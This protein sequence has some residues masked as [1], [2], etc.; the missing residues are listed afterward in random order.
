MSGPVENED[1]HG[2]QP[3][4]ATGAPLEV[5]EVAVVMVHGRGA[6]ANGMLGLA[7]EV[8]HSEIAYLAP[9]AFR[10]T[11]Y[12]QS[13]LAPIEANEPWLTSALGTVERALARLSE[14]GIER[15]RTVL[16]GFS[17]GACLATEFAARNPT[18]YGGIV[19]LSG[20]LIG[21]E[22]SEFEYGGSLECTPVFL[23]CSDVDPHIPVERVHETAEVFDGLGAAVEKRIYEGMGHTVN[24]EEIE[25]VN[26]LLDGLIDGE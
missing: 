19:G 21:P 20:G 1:P 6:T 11:W 16:L 15:E 2:E 9:Q 22:G 26:E 24:E 12:P 18:R 17:Q 14:A 3:I 10:S 7:R 25:A 23:G 4:E 13:F 8:W 5:A